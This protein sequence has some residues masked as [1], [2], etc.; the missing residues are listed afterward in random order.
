M[1]TRMFM[2][3]LSQPPKGGNTP[4]ALTGERTST[5]GLSVKDSVL[6]PEKG[7]QLSHTGGAPTT[8][9][10]LQEGSRTQEATRVQVQ[11]MPRLGQQN[12]R[13]SVLRR[14]QNRG[15]A[16]LLFKPPGLWHF[17]TAAQ[18]TLEGLLAPARV[19]G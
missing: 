9:S 6:R 5:Q 19:W 18:Q 16:F 13:P 11:E 4:S 2:A 17:L 8:L 3:A 15:D 7:V 12:R 14:F 10:L 1:C